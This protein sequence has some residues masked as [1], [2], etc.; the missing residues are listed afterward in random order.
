MAP[1][2]R[3]R[4]RGRQVARLRMR[5][6]LDGTAVAVA[7]PFPLPPSTGGD[8]NAQSQKRM[9]RFVSI[10]TKIES[11]GKRD[12]KEKKKLNNYRILSLVR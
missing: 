8:G 1:L 6:P 9:E 3:K 5:P 7:I 11:N 2:N 10:Q 4:Q 12:G